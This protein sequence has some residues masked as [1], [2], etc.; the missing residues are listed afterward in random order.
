[1]NPAVATAAKTYDLFIF[2]V[3]LLAMGMTSPQVLERFSQRLPLHRTIDVT[4]FLA[5]RMNLLICR[6]A[7]TSIYASL[8]PRHD[9]N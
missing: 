4:A 1:M 9:A 6:Y 8:K 7:I 2:F 5:N 3:L